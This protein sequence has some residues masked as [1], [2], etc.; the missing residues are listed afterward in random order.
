MASFLEKH[1][2]NYTH[3]FTTDEIINVFKILHPRNIVL[4]KDGVIVYNQAGGYK[5]IYKEIEEAIISALE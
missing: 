2:F 1:P 3:Y 4:D 5:D